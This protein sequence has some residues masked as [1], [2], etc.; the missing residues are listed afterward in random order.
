M[1]TSSPILPSPAAGHGE[2]RLA[3]RARRQGARRPPG[4]PPHRGALL[5]VLLPGVM[6]QKPWPAG[7]GGRRRQWGP[8]AAGAGELAGGEGEGHAPCGVERG[9][10]AAGWVAREGARRRG[11]EWEGGGRAL[12]L[13]GERGRELRGWVGRVGRGGGLGLQWAVNLGFVD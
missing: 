13:G 11:G 2:R 12:R 5:R 7:G 10:R 4:P 8:G 1:A 6:A 9:S 3:S